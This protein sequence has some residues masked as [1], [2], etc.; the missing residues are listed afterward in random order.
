MQSNVSKDGLVRTSLEG[1]LDAVCGLAVRQ[2]RDGD[3]GLDWDVVLEGLRI[4]RSFNASGSA[5]PSLDRTAGYRANARTPPQICVA[6]VSIELLTP[7]GDRAAQAAATVREKVCSEIAMHLPDVCFARVGQ[8]TVELIHAPTREGG[9]DAALVNLRK[10]LERPVDLGWRSVAIE[11]SIGFAQ[12]SIEGDPFET[13]IERAHRALV[14]AKLSHDKV[15]GF[16]EQDERERREKSALLRDL[17]RALRDEEFFLVYQPQVN[18]KTAR[19]CSVEA[20]LRWRHP[21]RGLVT[22]DH[23]IGLTEESGDIRA[24]TEYV[25][26]QAVRDHLALGALGQ[27]VPIAVNLSGCLLTDPD[28]TAWTLSALRSAPGAVS[29][30]VTET[31]VIS[32]PDIALEQLHRFVDAGVRLA[33]DDYGSGLSS[34]SYLKQIPAQELKID[35]AFVKSLTSSHRDPLL[36]RSTIDLAH[37]L[38]MEVTAEGVEH[39]MTLS[40]L[41]IMG[42]DI[43]QGYFIS[44]PLELGRLQTFLGTF[45]VERL[46]GAPQSPIL[47]LSQRGGSQTG[48]G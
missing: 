19:V 14:R 46:L 30:E 9:L 10:K 7:L 38:E 21:G 25:I 48:A 29:L 37:A 1:A 27:S 24:L 8:S 4:L 33:I 47:G 32:H 35:R 23:F 42:C 28:F 13:L 20:L 15:A 6:V 43:V 12:S 34:L 11:V 39:P 44:E 2:K 22:P 41:K 26:R 16:T 5:S 45:D 40:L 18:L 31:A 3:G 36:V 17:R